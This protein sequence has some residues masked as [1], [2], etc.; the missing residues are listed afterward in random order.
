MN[1]YAG[2]HKGP[3]PSSTSTP[4]PTGIPSRCLERRLPGS[5]LER[6][7]DCH[8]E[9]S[10]GSLGPSSQTLRCAQGDRQ[11]LHMSAFHPGNLPPNL[12]TDIIPAI[13]SSLITSPLIADTYQG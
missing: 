5:G 4:A 2:D 6:C 3:H 11:D 1:R 8:P 7:P 9:R 12:N 13:R 10:E